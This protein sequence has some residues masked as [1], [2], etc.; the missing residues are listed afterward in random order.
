MNDS[1]SA[2]EASGSKSVHI[3]RKNERRDEDRIIRWNKERVGR[4]RRR[5]RRVER[6]L[7]RDKG[8][9]KSQMTERL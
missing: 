4:R 9:L 6:G 5:R 1:S 2:A 3:E 7:K 8:R